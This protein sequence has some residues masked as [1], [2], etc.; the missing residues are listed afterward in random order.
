VNLGVP[1]YYRIGMFCAKH[2]YL[3]PPK[4]TEKVNDG[5]VNAKRYFSTCPAIA[6]L[7]RRK[8]IQHNRKQTA[9][10]AAVLNK[11]AAAAVA[12][13]LIPGDSAAGSRF[14][15]ASARSRSTQPCEGFVKES[16]AAVG[17]C[18]EV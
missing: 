12:I 5:A 3:A 1:H 17:S 15:T 7:F 6:R 2:L 10:N 14:A 18:S 16:G 9:F 11:L 8:A 13:E 4:P